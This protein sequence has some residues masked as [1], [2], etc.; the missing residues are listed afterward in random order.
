MELNECSSDNMTLRNQ[1]R[2]AARIM[3]CGVTRVWI[4]P[5]R[6]KD[7]QEAITGQDIRRLVND[8]I[9]KKL[10]K[11]GLSSYRRNKIRLQKKKGRRQ[12]IGKRK[13]HA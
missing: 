3:K 2:V 9:I 5:E 11:Q 7:A 12:G 13:G 6:I 10:P 1:K 4:N 8:G